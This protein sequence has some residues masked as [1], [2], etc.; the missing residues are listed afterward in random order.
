MLP[1]R[2]SQLREISSPHGPNRSRA[3]VQPYN[4]GVGDKLHS[5]LGFVESQMYGSR[6]WAEI[7][8]FSVNTP[9]RRG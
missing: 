8:E 2:V 9:A 6:E 5:D 7:A 3:L 1:Q 4:N